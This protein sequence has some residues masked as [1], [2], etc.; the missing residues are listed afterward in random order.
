MR[1]ALVGAA[2][3][4][5]ACSPS[6]TEL[7][8]SAKTSHGNLVITSYDH[9]AAS[10][11]MVTINGTYRIDGQTIPPMGELRVPLTDFSTSDGSRLFPAFV[12]TKE[13]AFTCSKPVPLQANLG[14][15]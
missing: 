10:E 5:A 2:A 14:Q 7:N 15:N 12:R 13:I 1:L 11:C 9:R 4:L 8:I 3:I 6:V